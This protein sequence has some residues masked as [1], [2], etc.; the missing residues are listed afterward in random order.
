MR[1]TNRTG[2]KEEK[3]RDSERYKVK[4]RVRERKERKK[5]TE[6]KGDKRKKRKGADSV[7]VSESVSMREK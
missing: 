1:E 3:A 7:R 2:G 6:R 5:E 4:Q